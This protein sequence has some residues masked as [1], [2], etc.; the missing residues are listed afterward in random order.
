MYGPRAA[1]YYLS[2][3]H[4][5]VCICFLIEREKEEEKYKIFVIL[6]F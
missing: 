3:V 1:A 4:K 5:D 6:F 2:K